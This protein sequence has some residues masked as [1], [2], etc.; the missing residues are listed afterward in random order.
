MLMPL[1][2]LPLCAQSTAFK[3]ASLPACCQVTARVC[4]LRNARMGAPPQRA[5]P[6]HHTP[7]GG[8]G[9]NTTTIATLQAYVPVSST[10]RAASPL[11]LDHRAAAMGSRRSSTAGEPG[12]PLLHTC[13]GCMLAHLEDQGVETLIRDKVRVRPAGGRSLPPPP[14]PP[15]L[16]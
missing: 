4:R 2:A 1:G 8:T 7:P 16:P 13:L 10:G 6:W 9:Y 14:R 5:D 3:A 12:R 15:G 11:P